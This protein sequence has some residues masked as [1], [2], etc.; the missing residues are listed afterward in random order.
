M[1][2]I[3]LVL[4]LLFT[5][6]LWAE[7]LVLGGVSLNG[8][9][10][11]GGLVIGRGLPGTEVSLDEQKVRVS[12]QGL[13]SLGFDRDAPATMQLSLALP[14]GST[15]A[16]RLDIARRDYNIQRIEGIAKKIMSPSEQ[17]LKRIR[18]EAA[19]V[20]AARAAIQQREDFAGQFV[21]PLTGPIT[22]VFGSQRVYNGQPKRP[23]YGVDVAAPTGTPLST[24]ASG[25]VTLAHDDM[26]YSGGTLIIDHGY[27][28]SS[29]LM[30]L[31]KV[32]VKVGDVV[33]PGDIVAEVGASGRATGPHL[34][35][36]MNWYQS[37]IDPQLLV[38]AMPK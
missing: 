4:T 8:H 6:K 35:W 5:P 3:L 18:A 31:S 10:I 21:W 20:R 22:G 9:F 30:H 37:R 29:T 33:Q 15:L 32:L 26:F 17:D 11:Q 1:L 28:V 36:R 16:H 24:P 27:G 12:E 19:Q 2:K 38:E 7:E 14:D 25:I 13:F 34:D 23:H